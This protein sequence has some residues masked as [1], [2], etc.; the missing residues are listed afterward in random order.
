MT[1]QQQLKDP[2]WQRLRLSVF[3]RDNWE[4]T[5]CQDTKSELQVHHKQYIAG[6]KA[7]NYSTDMLVTLCVNC[8]YNVTV[9][10]MLAKHGLTGEQLKK[11]NFSFGNCSGNADKLDAIIE[12]I[13]RL[14]SFEHSDLEAYIL[15]T[16]VKLFQ[17]G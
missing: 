1:Y 16:E 14:S 13:Y 10:D 11:L 7:W 5:K 17:H 4:C 8:H 12:L 6:F 15:E 2:R 9:N 3:E